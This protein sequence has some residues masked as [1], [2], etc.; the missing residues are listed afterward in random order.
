MGQVSSYTGIALN[1]VQ[2]SA[3]DLSAVK[4]IVTL[5][6]IG[7]FAWDNVKTSIF[8]K[9]YVAPVAR[10][11]TLK[12]PTPAVGDEF[13]VQLNQ[14]VDGVTVVNKT[15]SVVATTTSANDVA[16]ACNSALQGLITAGIIKGSTS[17]STDTITL[18]GTTSNP[19]LRVVGATTGI[20][21][22]AT[23]AGSAEVNGGD[24]LIK[25]NV[26]GAISGKEYTT[27][28]FS[29]EDSGVTRKIVYAID[30]DASNASDL[31]AAMTAVLGGGQ[32][33]TSPNV[34]NVNLVGKIAS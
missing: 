23:T 26:M 34:A 19:M 20:T 2:A 8:K 11:T 13:T 18:S 14:V 29:I 12:F 7:S 16:A 28:S 10:V 25:E 5:T 17:V 1:T 30:Q 9:V 27:F 22:T 21:V 6:G 15:V 33:A 24:M 32:S 31:I 3:A 4:G